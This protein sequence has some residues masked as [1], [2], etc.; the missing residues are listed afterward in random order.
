MKVFVVHVVQHVVHAVLWK[1]ALI[2]NALLFVVCR[3]SFVVV[4]RRLSLSLSLST[5]RCWVVRCWV[6]RRSSFVLRRVSHGSSFVRRSSL[7]VAYL[8]SFA[9]AF[10]DVGVHRTV[11]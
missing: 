2:D 3:S 6:V 1:T 10:A 5:V 9:K 8:S 11:D 4:V 7:V